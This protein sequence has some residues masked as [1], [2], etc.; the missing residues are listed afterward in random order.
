MSY[1]S[2]LDLCPPDPV[3][4]QVATFRADKRPEKISL[5]VGYYRDDEGQ[6]PAFQA[7]KE[8]AVGFFP[9]AEYL[10]MGGDE[11]YLDALEAL[12][13][14]CRPKQLCRVQAIGGTGA[15]RT[16]GDLLKQMGHHAIWLSDPTW[17]NHWGI[18]Q[19]A[20][21]KVE[22][23]PY[24]D[25]VNHGVAFESMMEALKGIPEKS[26]VLLHAICHNPTG[27]DLTKE[28]WSA[29]ADLMERRDLFPIFDL[30]YQG[31][32]QDAV[33][34]THAIQLFVE[35][36]FEMAVAYSCSKSFALYGE[37]VGALFV[38]SK[39]SDAALSSHMKRVCRTTYSNPPH[40]GAA[41]VHRVLTSKELRAL[42]EK[43]LEEMR[44]RMDAIRHL[45]TKKLNEKDPAGKWDFFLKGR[46][47]FIYSGL[48]EVAC[49]RLT[50]E[51]AIYIPSNG[52]INVTAI[53]KANVDHIAQAIAKCRQEDR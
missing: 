40:F 1:F 23:Y 29:L 18:F 52:R 35:R 34:D 15:L 20:G 6:T 49:E 45:F 42:W 36:G 9:P 28:Q 50:H 31:F 19:A 32:G 33:E 14:S 21:L 10:P 41:L 24:H 53:N 13:F 4:G 47:L 37:R 43:E 27:F 16:I 7:I 22:T 3:F 51:H 26:P 39:G 25:A 11:S 12:I 8:A 2:S 38:I 46:G 48:S 30:A 5:L 17:P 44:A